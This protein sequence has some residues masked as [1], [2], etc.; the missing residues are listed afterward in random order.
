MS[1]VP[2]SLAGHVREHP[3]QSQMLA[4]DGSRDARVRVAGA[5]DG[6]IAVGD[7]ISVGLQQDSV[8]PSVATSVAGSPSVSEPAPAR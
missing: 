1:G 3:S 4:V 6:E 5:L 7:G 2:C 8:L